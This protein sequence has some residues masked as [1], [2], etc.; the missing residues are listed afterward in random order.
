MQNNRIVLANQLIETNKYN[1]IDNTIRNAI[2]EV[3]GID[4]SILDMAETNVI[5]RNR[6]MCRV[7]DVINELHTM[8]YNPKTETIAKT[9]TIEN[10]TVA[11]VPTETILGTNGTIESTNEAFEIELEDSEDESFLLQTTQ[12]TIVVPTKDLIKLKG[13]D[14]RVVLGISAISNVENNTLSGK[15]KRYIS[16]DKVD[17]NMDKLCKT[18]DISPSQFRK[19]IR[20]LLKADSDEFRLVEK[21]HNDKMVK[22]YEIEYDKGGFI[23]V[24]IEKAKS[25]LIGGSN[26][27]IK[28][29]SN[30]L[31]LCNENG[32]FVEKE[33]TQSYLA[34]LMGYSKRSEEIIKIATKWLEGANLIKTEK[35]WVS[36]TIFK[37]GLPIGSKPKNKIYYS[38]VVD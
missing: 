27:C 30:L 28:L 19:H 26:H 17:K 37:D 7:I 18:I 16:I 24:P 21:M 11:E 4:K 9:E 20:T 33:L 23:T 12:N 36:E 32:E 6:Y 10:T 3:Y 14:F 31:W 13:T 34:T 35:V 38:I 2:V 1:N 29:Y 15:N 8:G 5:I 22:C 25:L